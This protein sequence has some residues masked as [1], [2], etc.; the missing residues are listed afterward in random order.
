MNKFI[1]LHYVDGE[2]VIVNVDRI[3]LVLNSREGA[4]VHLATHLE[5]TRRILYVKETYQ[6]IRRELLP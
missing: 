2:S 6:Y 5:S 3:S 1:E 4:V